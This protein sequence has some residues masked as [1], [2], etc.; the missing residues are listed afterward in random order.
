MPWQ[1]EP[2]S[3]LIMS[4][5][6]ICVLLMVS[7]AQI[8]WSSDACST[9][10]IHTFADV[11][12][13]DGSSF[14]T[15]SFFQSKDV[16]AIRHFLDEEQ[17]IA[18]EGPSSWV[19]SGDSAEAGT[20]FHKDS[21]LG[22]QFHAYLLHF[23]EIVANVRQTS[24]IQ[25]RGSTYRATSGD[26]PNGGV[27]HLIAG[28]DPDRPVG[29]LFDNDAVSIAFSFFDWREL[30]GESIP[31]HVQIDD[32]ERIFDYR[33]SGI[34]LT[35]KSPL[36][37]MNTLPAPEID[38]VQVYRLHRKLLAA[39]CLG[40]A[41]M[42]ADLSAPNIVV[43]SRGELMETSQEITRERFTSV[44]QRLD[45]TEYHDLAI[46]I[47]DVSSSGDIGWIGVNVRAVGKVIDSGD[48]FDDQ[49]AWVMM[50]RKIDDV[51]VHAGNAS[52]SLP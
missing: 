33:Y 19:L 31:F 40:D 48:S 35:P 1:V 30:G 43:A 51:W 18:V 17:I 32:G 49:W 45:Y 20:E 15:E 3:K 6:S 50:V 9:Q 25:F 44:F 11:S 24:E 37:F 52:N 41:D 8:S 5:K 12:V 36:W 47:I 23:D 14:R 38:E 34:D 13:S 39:H 28:E 26:K 27:A 2:G 29:L 4:F 22:H 42:M 46:P 16:A 7:N 10:A 21:A